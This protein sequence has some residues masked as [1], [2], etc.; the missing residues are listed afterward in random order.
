MAGLGI[1]RV[2]DLLCQG[3]S[4]LIQQLK[5]ML[6]AV[7]LPPRIDAETDDESVQNRFTR[8]DREQPDR[9]ESDRLNH[10]CRA[11][12]TDDDAPQ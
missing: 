10:P 2:K 4:S 1:F 9:E 6:A 11:T 5:P 12:E 7:L 3:S 8:D